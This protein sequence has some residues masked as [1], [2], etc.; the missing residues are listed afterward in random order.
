MSFYGLRDSNSPS[1]S[2]L[3]EF[4]ADFC[5]TRPFH[6]HPGLILISPGL[7]FLGPDLPN[8]SMI[9]GYGNPT[10]G[11]GEPTSF[12]PP[13]PVPV[14]GA[15]GRS[16]P[17]RNLGPDQ[18]RPGEMQKHLMALGN[19]AGS[20]EAASDPYELTDSEIEQQLGEQQQ[21]HQQQQLA[22]L[23]QQQQQTPIPGGVV[24]E[25]THPQLQH[26]QQALLTQQQQQQQGSDLELQQQ[27]DA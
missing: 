3:S 23:V 24:P 12:G 6:P 4:E 14:V 17:A 16:R 26:Q 5:D 25:Q 2:E 7:P 22:A 11:F 18:M 8:E 20:P 10:R 1:V 27:H 9:G 19:L 13:S 15:R 21:Q